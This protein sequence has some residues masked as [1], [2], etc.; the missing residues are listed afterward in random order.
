MNELV[1]QHFKRPYGIAHIPAAPG[2]VRVALRSRQVG[3]AVDF[4][5]KASH[6]KVEAIRYRVK[7]CAYTIA[8][9][10]YLAKWLEGHPLQDLQLVRRETLAKV[11]DLPS[12]KV[13]CAAFAQTALTRALRQLEQQHA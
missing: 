3:R 12:N 5:L 6:G 13:H 7:G 10:S 11:L 4:Y 8:T 9:F 2:V 1:L